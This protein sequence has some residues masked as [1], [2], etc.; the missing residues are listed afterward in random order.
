MKKIVILSGDPN[1]INSEL[2]YKVW[3]KIN[4]SIKKKIYLISNY[5]LLTKQF[6]KLKLPIKLIKVKNLNESPNINKLKII[7][8]NLSFKDSFKVSNYQSSKFFLKSLNLAHKYSINGYI[9]GFINCPID[10]KLLNKNTG[11]TEFLASKCSIKDNSEAM[12][13][14]NK[15]LSVSPIT[16]H[17]DVKKISKTITSKK[18]IAKITT[19][20]SWFKKN[21]KIK[22]KIAV[23]GLNPH[24]SEFNKKS[25]EL[26]IIKPAIVKL[27]K[28]NINISGP[29]ASDSF[30]VED[31]KKYNVIIG[32]Y[33]DQVLTPFKT[34][35]GF[36]AINITLGLDYLRVSPDHG[37]ATKL[38]GKNKA[39]SSSLL[40]CIDFLDKF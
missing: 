6:K 34:L 20:E 38:I 22:P 7:N 29:Y 1:S 31:Y 11:V 24:N 10:K 19:I 3:K 36:N 28:N 21:L 12:L 5:D 40:S 35:F 4:K 32:M 23:L 16:T 14:T 9:Q 17:I 26:K 27:K 39:N 33:H 37:V 25:E 30:F 15:K 18:I 2:I 13:I 8:V